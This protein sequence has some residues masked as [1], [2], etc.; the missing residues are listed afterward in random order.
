MHRKGNTMSSSR[1]F[2]ARIAAAGTPVS[3]SARSRVY[4]STLAAY[5][6]YY[7]LTTSAPNQ[8]P[9]PAAFSGT[10]LSNSDPVGAAGKCA[11][12]PLRPRGA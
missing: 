3:R 8:K 4:G 12:S 9:D 10:L 6:D 11:T 1:R 5:L 7:G 2:L